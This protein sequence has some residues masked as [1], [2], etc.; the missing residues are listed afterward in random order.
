MIFA[1]KPD[2]I[3]TYRTEDVCEELKVLSA[4]EFMSTQ[5]CPRPLKTGA[6]TFS[7]CPAFFE[8]R[9]LGYIFRSPVTI[10]VKIDSEG[11][12][13]TRGEDGYENFIESHPIDQHAPFYQGYR[14]LK[15]TTGIGVFA[16][17]SM[18]Y[19]Y[20]GAVFQNKTLTQSGVCVPT[21]VSDAKTN[22]LMNAFIGIQIPVEGYETAITIM[23]G[24]PICQLIPMID[25]V[26]VKHVVDPYY[27]TNNSLRNNLEEGLNAVRKGVGRLL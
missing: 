27:I 17:K 16:P 6:H 24:D 14:F 1:K 7:N 10:E 3:F 11:G 4:K 25:D 2:L 13:Y 5:K 23:K 18:R 12:L 20:Q 15:I 22:N 9:K 8:T 19:I 21:A 26:V